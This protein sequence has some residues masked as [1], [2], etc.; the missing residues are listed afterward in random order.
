M[1]GSTFD[2]VR[3]QI[4]D[5]FRRI[6]TGGSEPALAVAWITDDGDDG[7]FGPDSVAWRVHGDL[8]T[9]VG[10]LRALLLQTL[11]PLAMAGVAQ[12]SAYRS[13]P[14]G[15]LQRTAGFLVATIFGT[16]ADAEAAVATVR[17]VH[18]R[19][20]GTAPDGRP[21]AATD[22]H[23]IT[24]VHVTE[25]DSFLAAHQALSTDPLSDDDADRYVAEMGEIAR[26]LGGED[27]PTDVA[28]LRRWLD[29]VRCELSLGADARRALRFLLNPP[30]PL[31]AR[32]A[33]ALVAS[34]AIG[35]LPFWAQRALYLPAVPA[36]DRLAVRPAMR[37]ALGVLGWAL[38]APP[39]EEAAR[40]R[41]GLPSGAEPAFGS[42]ADDE[43]L[44]LR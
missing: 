10:G 22:P 5:S 9:L 43:A 31:F 27:V 24:F 17:H 38:G 37:S 8:A 13:D 14:F 4:A 15:R 35:L 29:E 41:A 40:R 12:H 23:L 30:L 32:P 21:Y 2:P 20:R 44:D 26:R 25:V 36:V 11:H 18:E 1:L 39:Q 42:L 6:L 28:S 16:T 7:W 33:Y 19:V 3:N 34:A